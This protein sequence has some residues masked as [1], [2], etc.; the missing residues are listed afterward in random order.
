M[1]ATLAELLRLDW[2]RDSKRTSVSSFL[3]ATD[4]AGALAALWEL[5]VA[6]KQGFID[7][8]RVA[9]ESPASFSFHIYSKEDGSANTINDLVHVIS[10]SQYFSESN[11]NIP[12]LNKDTVQKGSLYIEFDEDSVGEQSDMTVEL[13]LVALD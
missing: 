11:L 2:L 10:I 4:S 6:V 5:P 3:C 9:S 7:T 12:F 1:S 13:C 8:I